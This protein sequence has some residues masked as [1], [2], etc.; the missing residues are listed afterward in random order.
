MNT[1]RCAACGRSTITTE[2]VQDKDGESVWVGRECARWVRQSGEYGYQ[3]PL[4]GPRLYPL[5]GAK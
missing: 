5:E 4:G 2:E 3:P 1:Y